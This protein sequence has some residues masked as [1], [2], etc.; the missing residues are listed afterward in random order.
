MKPITLEELNKKKEKLKLINEKLNTLQPI[1]KELKDDENV[2]KY[3]ELSEEFQEACDIL[4]KLIDDVKYQ[5]M[6]H[7]NHYFVINRQGSY[8]DGHRYEKTEVR[9]CIHCG[10]TDD[11]MEHY[12][13]DNFS[14]YNIMNEVFINSSA[15]SAPTHGFYDYLEID[16]VKKEYD[17]F[18][19]EYPDATD[20]VIDE[21]IKLVKKMKGG[22]LC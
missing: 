3:I 4:V 12:G 2:K 11:Y 17:K 13:D 8:F 18:K 9:T 6:Y 14:R 19:S 10:L 1:I 22:K 7:C 16:S 15:A 20:D 5:S 21:H